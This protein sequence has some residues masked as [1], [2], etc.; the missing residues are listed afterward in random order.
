MGFCSVDDINA[1][2]PSG[3]QTPQ[4]VVEADDVN[5][6]LLQ[7]SVARV[8]RGYLSGT[9]STA[10]MASW[11]EPDHTPDVIREVAAKLIA[12]QLYFNQVSA[13]SLNIEDRHYSQILYDQAMAMLNGIVAGTIIIEDVPVETPNFMTVDDFFPVDDTDRAF[14]M[15]LEL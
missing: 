11:D 2:L 14:S 15:S 5:V 10:T 9:L 7:I 12:A 8:V 3:D 6:E 4:V 1:N 13:T